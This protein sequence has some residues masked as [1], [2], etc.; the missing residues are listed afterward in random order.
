MITVFK[1]TSLT[2]NIE[3]LFCV[4]QQPDTFRKVIKCVYYKIKLKQS[5]FERNAKKI[6]GFEHF[7]SQIC[8]N[9]NTQ[10]RVIFVQ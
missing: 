9:E 1:V 2:C 8:D 4:S 3:L 5:H 7:S 10:I 6:L